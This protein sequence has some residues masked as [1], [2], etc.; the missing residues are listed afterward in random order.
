MEVIMFSK[1]HVA[2]LV[3]EFVGTAVLALAV[4]SVVNSQLGV[5]FFVALGAGLALLLMVFSLGRVSGTHLNPAVTV[6]FWS[7]RQISTIKAITYIAVQMLGGYA[8]FALF[9]YLS[10]AEG[11]T[12]RATGYDSQVLVAEVLGTAVFTFGIAAAVANNLQIGAK[13]A[14]IGGSLTLAIIIA[15]VASPAFLNPAVALAN[16]SWEL[17]TFVLGPVLGAIIGFNLY[18]LLFSVA[19]APVKAPKVK[20]EKKPAPKAKSSKIAAKK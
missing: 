16:Q 14:A 6:G 15:S 2:A 7:V 4:L 17:S 9:S 20:V 3:G 19:T 13:A 12:N 5:A 8:A 11:W 18:T 1:Q 10:G